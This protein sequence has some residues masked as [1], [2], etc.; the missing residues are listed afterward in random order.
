M[1]VRGGI[2]PLFFTD[3]P[4]LP[5]SGICLLLICNNPSDI[6]QCRNHRAVSR[7]K[8]RQTRQ[9][10]SQRVS[11]IPKLTQSSTFTVQE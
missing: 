3:L 6:C 10:L 1:D 2:C 4:D 9:F 8:R 5:H 11:K 7:T